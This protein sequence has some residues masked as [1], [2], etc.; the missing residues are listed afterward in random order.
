MQLILEEV[1]AIQERIQKDIA[2]LPSLKVKTEETLL[3]IQEERQLID[4]A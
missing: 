3:K 1:K 2:H 4:L